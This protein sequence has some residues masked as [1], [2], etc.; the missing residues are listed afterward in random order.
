MAFARSLG[1]KYRSQLTPERKDKILRLLTA[2]LP[3]RRRRGRPRDPMVTRAMR[4]R[5]SFRRKYP[6]EKPRQTWDRICVAL[7]SG[8]DGLPEW[9]HLAAREDLQARVKSRVD[10]IRRKR[11]QKI[12]GEISA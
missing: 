1:K 7:I 3:P 8:Y 4:L 5:G 9:E 10:L 6:H 11:R 12:R 2:V